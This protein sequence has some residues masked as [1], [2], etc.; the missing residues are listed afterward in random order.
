MNKRVAEV[1]A[2]RELLV[3]H[4]SL[5]RLRLELQ[6][7]SVLRSLSFVDRGAEAVR[8]VKRHPGIIFAA[9]ALFAALL[10]SRRVFSGLLGGLRLWSAVRR[11]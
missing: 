6:T 8:Y 11:L 3:A 1:T 4:S 5:Q 7:A 2:R 10:R 9:A